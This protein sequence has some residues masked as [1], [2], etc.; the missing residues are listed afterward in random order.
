MH[1]CRQHPTRPRARASPRPFLLLR[2]RAPPQRWV[3]S[4]G[5][6]WRAAVSDRRDRGRAPAASRVGAACAGV[7]LRRTAGRAGNRCVEGGRG[8]S[9]RGVGAGVGAEEVRAAEAHAAE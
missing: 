1:R 4:G 5:Y 2:C 7:A 8:G 9:E 6:R 3:P